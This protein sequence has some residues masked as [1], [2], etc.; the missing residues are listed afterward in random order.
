[1]IDQFNKMIITS[2]STFSIFHTNVASLNLH[3]DDFRLI[4]SRLEHKFDIIGISEHKIQEGKPASN[5]I[6]LTG[7]KKFIFEP[8]CTTHGG[9]G[10]YIKD[11]LDYNTRKDLQINS[12]GDF[13]SSFIELLVIDSLNCIYWH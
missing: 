11:N 13:E 1:M 3:I 7:Y 10:C 6:K 5:N 2:P 4:L 9:T 8:T 12:P